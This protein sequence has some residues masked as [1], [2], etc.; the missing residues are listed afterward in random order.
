MRSFSISLRALALAA[1]ALATVSSS[2]AQT[3][4]PDREKLAQTGMKFL[5][6]PGDPRAA[7][8]GSAA[9]AMEGG[10]EML[11]ANPAGMAWTRETTDLMIGQTQF[12][13]DINYNHASAAFRPGNGR[14]GVIGFTLTSVDYGTF[15]ETIRADNEQGFIDLGEFSPQAY[16]VGVGYARAL[17]DRFSVGGQVKYANQNLGDSV[18]QPGETEDT[19]TRQTNEQ[20]VLAYD[21]GVQYK[22]GFESLNFAVAARNFS[23]EIAFEEELFQLPLT[24]QIGISMDVIDLTSLNGNTHRFLVAVDA[25]NPR[26]FS[27]QIKV[28]G[29]YTFLNAFSLRGGYV[30]PADEQGIH[31]GAGVQQSV[32][33]L[34][35]AADYGYSDYGVFSAV[36]RV[37]VRLSL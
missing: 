37:A 14:F 11:F 30:F 29:E 1:V 31:L 18:S 10:S 19:F 2:S 35:L 22:T 8:M 16:A 36:H 5:S 24:L 20:G 34:G 21:F 26:D 3:D 12:L 32:G 23:Q 9:T 7:A 6:V 27:E 17:S 13:T 25:E 15:Q 28:G 4:T 33:G